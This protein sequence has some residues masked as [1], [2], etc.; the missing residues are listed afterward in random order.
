M[1][2]KYGR[3]IPL[4]SLYLQTRATYPPGLPMPLQFVQKKL[5]DMKMETD[6]LTLFAGISH[7]NGAPYA[8][9][10]KL[11]HY[12]E[13]GKVYCVRVPDEFAALQKKDNE[14]F[15][16]RASASYQ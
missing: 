3:R 9:A 12:Y 7:R 1:G 13:E 16:A 8:L 11:C 15:D 5:T 4:A 2:V 10:S 6:L 14:T